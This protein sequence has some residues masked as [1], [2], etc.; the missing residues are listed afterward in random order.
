ML[1]DNLGYFKNLTQD[2]ISEFKSIL[3]GDTPINFNIINKIN[4]SAGDMFAYK[5]WG[6]YNSIIELTSFYIK[7]RKKNILLHRLFHMILRSLLQTSTF[8]IT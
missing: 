8:W 3:T 1:I 5:Y 2:E 7:T 6:T 4:K